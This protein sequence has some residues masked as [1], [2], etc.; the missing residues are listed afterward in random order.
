M[1]TVTP[2][3]T[4]RDSN[5]VIIGVLET[6]PAGNGLYRVHHINA[7]TFAGNFPTEQALRTAGHE[8]NKPSQENQQ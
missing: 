3:Y 8:P 5:G 7:A 6:T 1:S 2:A 4:V